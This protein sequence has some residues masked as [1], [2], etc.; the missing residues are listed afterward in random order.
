[1][2]DQKQITQGAKFKIESGS[3]FIITSVETE[4]DITIVRSMLEGGARDAYANELEDC[5]SFLNEER[6]ELINADEIA[7]YNEFIS[8]YEPHAHK[9]NFEYW[10]TYYKTNSTHTG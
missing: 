4:K 1:M 5:I 10:Q 6:A 9:P 2:I 7:A 3:V 8:H